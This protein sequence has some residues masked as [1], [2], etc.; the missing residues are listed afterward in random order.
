MAILT[1]LL[2]AKPSKSNIRKILAIAKKEEFKT[3]QDEIVKARRSAIRRALNKNSAF[4]KQVN[5]QVVK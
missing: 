5:N 4:L 3:V 2:N 1:Q